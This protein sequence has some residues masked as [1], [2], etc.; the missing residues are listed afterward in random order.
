MKV[1]VSHGVEAQVRGI[2]C[3]EHFPHGSEVL[4]HDVLLNDV[5][6]GGEESGAHSVRKYLS[7]R[8]CVLYPV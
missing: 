3:C 5:P 6:L 7:E 1:E 8:N 4:L 2:Y